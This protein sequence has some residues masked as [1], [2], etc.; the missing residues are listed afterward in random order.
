[1]PR[2]LDR[3]QKAWGAFEADVDGGSSRRRLRQ[4]VKVHNQTRTKI[5][6]NKNCINRV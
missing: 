4:Y 6:T 1:M 5:K 3:H 2:L